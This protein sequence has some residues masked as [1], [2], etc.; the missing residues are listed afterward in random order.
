MILGIARS[1][2]N[3]RRYVF[4][5][6]S[7]EGSVIHVDI[8]VGVEAHGDSG[9]VSVGVQGWGV[10]LARFFLSCF[11]DHKIDVGEGQESQEL[12]QIV[13]EGHEVMIRNQQ[14]AKTVDDRGRWKAR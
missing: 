12:R 4:Y 3:F 7:S 6:N 10:R 1:R 9:R 5:L 11:V 8:V 13:C 2:Y 14:G